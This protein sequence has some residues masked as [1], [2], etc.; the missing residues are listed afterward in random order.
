MPTVYD[1]PVTG[2]QIGGAF[3]EAL[4]K[5]TGQGMSVR[6][7]PTQRK[8]RRIF[9]GGGGGGRSSTPAPTFRSELLKQS[10]SSR[11]ALIKAEEEFRQEQQRKEEEKQKEERERQERIQS[12][13]ISG[14]LKQA[15][16]LAIEQVEEGRLDRPFYQQSLASSIG[17]SARNIGSNIKTFFTGRD[18]EF[19]SI[20]S[21]FKFAEGKKF[22]EKAFT[23]PTFGTIQTDPF[24]GKAKTGDVTFGDL[25]RDIEMRREM[26]ISKA[27]TLA[28]TKADKIVRNI[29]SKVN[30]GKIGIDEAKKQASEK[31]EKVNKEFKEKQEKVFKKEQNIPGVFERTGKVRRGI[32]TAVDVGA[33]TASIGVGIVNPVAGASIA[34]GYFTGKGIKQTTEKPTIR[35]IKEQGGLFAG[36]GKSEQ[37][38]I[39]LLEPTELDVEF[40]QKRIEGGINLL[41][42]SASAFGLVGASAKA[43]TLGRQ[44]ALAGKQ[45]KFISKEVAKGAD[46]SVLLR[47]K[48]IRKVPGAKQEV[49]ILSPTFP[50]GQKAGI[51]KFSVAGGRGISRTEVSRF[52]LE[53]AVPRG[54]EIIKATESFGVVGKGEVSRGILTGEKGVTLVSDDILGV[55]GKGDIII[56]DELRG[57]TFA[58]VGRKKGKVV[59]IISGE[60]KKVK[61]K[62]TLKLGVEDLGTEQK[63]ERFLLERRGAGKITA[64]GKLIRMTPG[65]IT[66]TRTATKETTPSFKIVSPKET[67]SPIAQKTLSLLKT[68]QAEELEAGGSVISAG[69]AQ[70]TTTPVLKPQASKVVAVPSQMLKERTQQKTKLIARELPKERVQ[71]TPVLKSGEAT[72]ELQKSMTKSMTVSQPKFQQ[73][74]KLAT[75]SIQRSRL[76][77]K[78]LQKQLTP[79]T[80]ITTPTISSPRGEFNYLGGF[81]FVPPII[82]FKPQLGRGKIKKRQRGEQPTQFQPSLTGSIFRIKGKPKKFGI[83]GYSPFQIRGIPSKRKFRII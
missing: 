59:D 71:F 72:K 65:D 21:P 43:V 45:F 37:G 16:P 78:T 51:Q 40:K 28:R 6:E 31:L 33:I 29:Q 44:Q 57:G 27:E 22:Q 62:P 30:E 53:G 70:K 32:K 67:A 42:G 79:Q 61:V 18:M 82:P 46:E 58:G 76:A 81:S 41:A 7:T 12:G 34:T 66:I 23:Q 38:K 83:Y 47:S 3:G 5:A 4:A 50:Q 1:D 2:K 49:E 48:F 64:K 8:I 63:V 39:K 11:E 26:E 77:Q 24:T 55:R 25:Q 9:G 68:Q 35:Q 19:K 15:Q 73:R 69:I 13:K 56:G 20:L 36:V 74:S 75:Q 10:F 14:Q 17:Q 60:I 80:S 52:E 54:K